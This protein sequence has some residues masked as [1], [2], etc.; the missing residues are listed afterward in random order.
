LT[1]RFKSWQADE[2]ASPALGDLGLSLG[3]MWAK[4]AASQGREIMA[5]LGYRRFDEMIGQMQMLDRPQTGGALE[6]QGSKKK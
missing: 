5:A 1:G 4:L 6:G 3:R 2:D